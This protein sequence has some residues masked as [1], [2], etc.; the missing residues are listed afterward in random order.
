MGLQ[1]HVSV[2]CVDAGPCMRPLGARAAMRPHGAGAGVGRMHWRGVSSSTR[3]PAMHSHSTSAAPKPSVPPPLPPPA[4]PPF[5]ASRPLFRTH[6]RRPY[7]KPTQPPTGG[8]KDEASGGGRPRLCYYIGIDKKAVAA[9][10]A[11]QL[12]PNGQASTCPRR[13]CPTPPPHCV[14]VF[15][16]VTCA[17]RSGIA[18]EVRLA[19]ESDACM[20]VH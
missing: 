10:T 3:C 12:L 16:L 9:A 18:C 4:P 13:A 5:T 11:A 14:L 20:Q 8:G 7:P 15:G 1:D 2:R 19:C 17:H 6:T